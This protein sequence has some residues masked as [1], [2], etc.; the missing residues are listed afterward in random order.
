MMSTRP[1]IV[2][3]IVTMTVCMRM[4]VGVIMSM[5]VVMMALLRGSHRR[6]HSVRAIPADMGEI[7]SEY[8]YI[9][10]TL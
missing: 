6:R 7:A 9:C 5:I 4:I 10:P 8:Y 2:G 3:M 1:V